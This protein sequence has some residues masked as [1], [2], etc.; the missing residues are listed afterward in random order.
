MER[1]SKATP[2][3]SGRALRRYNAEA[4]RQAQV[5]AHYEAIR[6]RRL[7]TGQTATQGAEVRQFDTGKSRNSDRS[8]AQAQKEKVNAHVMD[9]HISKSGGHERRSLRAIAHDRGLKHADTF[10]SNDPA[11]NPYWARRRGSHA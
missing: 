9:R 8:G 7:A 11:K 3:L 10:R 2:D 4:K 1:V 5:Q 6:A